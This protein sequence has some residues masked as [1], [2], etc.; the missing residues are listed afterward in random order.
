[1]T[2]T[3]ITMN[4]AAD[5]DRHDANTHTQTPRPGTS[6]EETAIASDATAF[7]I[8]QWR[9]SQSAKQHATE[10]KRRR[11]MNSRTF[12]RMSA[13]SRVKHAFDALEKRSQEQ[14]IMSE[15]DFK[16]L[17]QAIGNFRVRLDV[18][19]SKTLAELKQL[20][21]ETQIQE[22]AAAL[23]T[24]NAF[25]EKNDGGDDTKY[26][27]MKEIYRD[28]K[29]WREV[30]SNEI[31]TLEPKPKFNYSNIGGGLFKHV[32]A[33]ADPPGVPS[34]HAQIAHTSG[35]ALRNILTPETIRRKFISLKALTQKIS[36]EVA[37]FLTEE[38]RTD[39]RAEVVKQI[40]ESC[41]KALA[42]QN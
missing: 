30:L 42:Q 1:M 3:T 31:F 4:H 32:T 22:E 28:L 11:S 24:S 8:Q 27:Y 12:Y 14:R 35:I 39:D 10:M 23:E 26:L 36:E 9:F 18:H 40:K 6:D 21:A 34:Q 19:D 41:K 25:L 16:L 13:S 5:E 38:H 17:K 7:A 37:A 29:N 20:R 15:Q 33:A 2:T